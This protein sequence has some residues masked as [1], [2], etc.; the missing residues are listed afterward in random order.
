MRLAPEELLSLPRRQ[1]LSELRR[2]APEQSGT[3]AQRFSEL[4]AQL[5]CPDCGQVGCRY[6]RLASGREGF[7]KA[8]TW[9]SGDKGE[10]CGEA[11]KGWETAWNLLGLAK[12]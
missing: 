1:R 12:K 7:N 9:G 4:D 10:R 11:L 5:S 3:V 8:E 2:G 6:Q